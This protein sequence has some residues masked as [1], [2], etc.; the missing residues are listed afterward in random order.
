MSFLNWEEPLNVW[1]REIISVG[2]SCC[3]IFSCLSIYHILPFLPFI[4]DQAVP[5]FSGGGRP[6][7][8][9]KDGDGRNSVVCLDGQAATKADVERQV[10]A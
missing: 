3:L 6:S 1:K 2:L 7:R 4:S 8:R 9:G 10:T 5:G